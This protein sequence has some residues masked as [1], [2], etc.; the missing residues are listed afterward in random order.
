MIISII[1]EVGRIVRVG[2]RSPE[3]TKVAGMNIEVN[4]T[5]PGRKATQYDADMLFVAYRV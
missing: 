4:R 3:T 1:T 2:Y 5:G